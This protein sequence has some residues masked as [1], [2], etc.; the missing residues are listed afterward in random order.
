MRD[1][2][3]E[4]KTVPTVEDASKA[5]AELDID[6]FSR[7]YD[8]VHLLEPLDGPSGK[9]GNG[10]TNGSNIANSESEEDAECM[11]CMDNAVEVVLPDCNHA[12]CRK[13]LDEWTAVSK[14]CPMCRSITESNDS[15]WIMAENPTAEQLFDSLSELLQKLQNGG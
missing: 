13:C 10:E 2:N 7:F 6:Q 5:F 11:I 4:L 8:R 3:N 14:T 12:F 15:L 9:D 1:E